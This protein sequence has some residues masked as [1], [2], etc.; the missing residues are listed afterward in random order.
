MCSQVS[1]M[2]ACLVV[3]VPATLP[4]SCTEGNV[5]DTVNDKIF[6]GEKFCSLLGSSGMWEKI[7]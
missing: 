2:L 6:E 3:R 4:V 5:Q 7:S 1:R